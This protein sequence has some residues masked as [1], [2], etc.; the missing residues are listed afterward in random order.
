MVVLALAG[1]IDLLTEPAALAA[2]DDALADLPCPKTG[3]S[4]DR[5]PPDATVTLLVIDLSE[6]TFLSSKGL[7]LLITADRAAADRGLA[8]RIATG[9]HHSVLRPLQIGGLDGALPTSANLDEALTGHA[10]RATEQ[11]ATESPPTH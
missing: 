6:V 11:R 3:P 2:L 8:L 9:A 7:Q 4:P 1:E 10:H 5:A